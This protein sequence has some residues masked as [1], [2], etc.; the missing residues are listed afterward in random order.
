MCFSFLADLGLLSGLHS[1]SSAALQELEA[2]HANANAN[3]NSTSNSTAVG[4]KGSIVT[5]G[6]ETIESTAPLLSLDSTLNNSI[7][8]RMKSGDS[9]STIDSISSLSVDSEQR[10]HN[11]LKRDHRDMD[12]SSYATNVA[13]KRFAADYLVSPADLQHHANQM[14]VEEEDDDVG[15]S[16]DD[17][18][19]PP[20]RPLPASSTYR[21]QSDLNF[22]LS[23]SSSAGSTIPFSD[24]TNSL[25]SSVSDASSTD[26]YKGTSSS[27]AAASYV[28]SSSA[29]STSNI[30]GASST[31]S[32]L[33]PSS[34]SYGPSRTSTPSPNLPFHSSNSSNSLGMSSDNALT[35]ASSLSY[36]LPGVSNSS[37]INISFANLLPSTASNSS[38][39]LTSLLLPV[40]NVSTSSPSQLPSIPTMANTENNMSTSYLPVSSSLLPNHYH[41]QAIPQS[42]SLR[43]HQQYSHPHHQQQ[44][45]QQQ[46][47]Q[48]LQG[49][50]KGNDSFNGKGGGA[51]IGG[52]SHT[53]SSTHSSSSNNNNSNSNSNSVIGS[54]NIFSSLQEAFNSPLN[55][56]S[57]STSTG[58]PSSAPTGRMVHNSSVENFWYVFL[59]DIFLN[60]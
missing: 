21:S 11:S 35:T 36:V 43:Q 24:S 20:L 7:T 1:L 60:L 58:T 14:T 25:S 29:K 45:Q 12:S 34:S 22:S 54:K 23:A 59:C 30:S 47:F 39:S 10:N 27:T 26:I 6:G 44:Q 42:S 51:Y 40:S 13:S 41:G 32:S 8:P 56:G 9:C 31:L 28:S 4:G 33:G 16:L 52:D 17:V 15:Y 5:S 38:S 3:S 18:P 2:L 50:M 53:N 49:R 55:T 48:Q 46:Q 57:A 19:S 37:S